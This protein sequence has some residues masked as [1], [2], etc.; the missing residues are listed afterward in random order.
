M[1]NP[2]GGAASIVIAV[3]I[4]AHSMGPVSEGGQLSQNHWSIYLLLQSGG[5]Y[6]LNMTTNPAPGQDE[7]I[8][9]TTENADDLTRSCVRY[10]DFDAV[11]GL[12][13]AHVLGLIAQK[14]RQRYRMTG[15]GVGCRH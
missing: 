1:S 12:T 4:V 15:S 3:R 7:G 2:A 13:V 8:F 5:S 10:W 14:G 6:R 11:S 9:E